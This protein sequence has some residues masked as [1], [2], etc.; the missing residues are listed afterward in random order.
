MQLDFRNAAA[1]DAIADELT[2]I[3]AEMSIMRRNTLVRI[4]AK[5]SQM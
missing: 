3:R 2:L 1:A 5:L 4:A